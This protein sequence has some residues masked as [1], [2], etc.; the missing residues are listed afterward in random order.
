MIVNGKA[1][2][3]WIWKAAKVRVIEHRRLH[4]QDTTAGAHRME[5]KELLSIFTRTMTCV[6]V[7]EYQED[8]YID[9]MI[10]MSATT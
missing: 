7:S 10:L 4:V 2:G 1:F 3:S 8:V 9:R 5:Q 6:S